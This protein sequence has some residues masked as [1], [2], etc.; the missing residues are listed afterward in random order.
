M[1]NI[2]TALILVVIGL[3]AMMTLYL[4]PALFLFVF[5]VLYRSI[6]HRL[7]IKEAILDVWYDDETYN[8]AHSTPQ[9][10]LSKYTYHKEQDKS[11]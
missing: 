9:A 8:D 6:F 10:D 5:R 7:G 1:N 4:L 2:I 3:I 11:L